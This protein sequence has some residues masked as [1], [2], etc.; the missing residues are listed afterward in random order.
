MG[1]DPR[2]LKGIDFFNAREFFDA[3]EVWEELWHETQGEP[4]NFIQGLIQ[5]ATAL[6]HFQNS[7]L[8]GAKLLYQSFVDL[9]APTPDRYMGMNVEK[10][11]NE[12]NACFR[13]LAPY[14]VDSL[15]GRYTSGKERFPVQ[16]EES[17][18][19]QI[20]LQ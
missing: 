13:W 16:M 9:L 14:S 2:Y 15:P 12:L 5:A 20:K 17:K 18:I 6:H 7:N 8:K 4:R 3:H 19:P 10:F 1:Y 11:K